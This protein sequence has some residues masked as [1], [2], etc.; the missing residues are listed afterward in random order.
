MT[1][2]AAIDI[3]T[4]TTR[5]LVADAGPDGV[6]E[7]S[8]R[9]V[10]THLGDGWTGTGLLSR[11]AIERVA[12]AVRSF[13]AEA[14]ALGATDIFGVATSASRDAGNSGEF[15]DAL[16]AAGMRPQIIAGTTEAQLSFLGATYGRDGEGI[17]VVDIGGGS[18]E[19]VVG[20][21]DEDGE[22]DIE[23]ARSIDIGAKR[24]TELY[25]HGDPPARH[26]LDAA[27][28]FITEELRPYF[29]ALRSRPR[30]LVAVAG[31]ATSLAAIDLELEEYDASRV[32][33][34][35]LGAHALADMREMLATMTLESRRAVTGLEPARAGVIVAGALILETVLALAG[36]DST[37]VSEQDI[38][39]GMVLDRA[40]LTGGELI[41]TL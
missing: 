25:L 39:Y 33:G 35:V 26:E 30:E 6:R 13:V 5:L 4:V 32:H 29:A 31:T 23:A 24:V 15:L 28:A 38:L 17:L 14:R 3:G 12:E 2:Y 20:D 22:I 16:E 41:G 40:G 1:R 34:Y 11:E 18:T 8:R 21:V 9:S 10:I 27:N 36:L 7:L 37:L 19:L